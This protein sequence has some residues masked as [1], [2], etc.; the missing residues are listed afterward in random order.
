MEPLSVWGDGN[1]GGG[2]RDDSMGER[3]VFLK[4]RMINSTCIL[5][6]PYA[7]TV[8]EWKVHVVSSSLSA[9]FMVLWW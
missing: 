5:I 1:E 7:A 6:S 3:S 8:A 4:G 2:R 9:H